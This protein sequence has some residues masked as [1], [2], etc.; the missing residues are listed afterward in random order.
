MRNPWPLAKV[1]NTEVP[2]AER[3]RGAREF[4]DMRACC[5]DAWCGQPLRGPICESWR[6][7][8]EADLH[9][10]MRAMFSRCVLTSTFI[11][12]CFA[13]LTTFTGA[14][15]SRHT[16]P[17]VASH[18]LLTV[19]DAA[20]KKW[21]ETLD[22]ATTS[23]NK[24]RPVTVKT[25]P[26]GRGTCGWH[27]YVAEKPLANYSSPQG[28]M[29]E[30]QAKMARW[31]RL[32]A[33]EQ[34]PYIAKAKK[35]RLAAKNQGSALDNAL[36][37]K[38]EE[39]G[40]PW[41]LSAC[42]KEVRADSSDGLGPGRSPSDWPIARVHIEQQMRELNLA[43]SCERWRREEGQVWGEDLD[44]PDTVS[45]AEPC[46]EGEC[47][48]VLTEAQRGKVAALGKHL[49]L[50]LRN[51]G[52]PPELLP[53]LE[54]TGCGHIIY[55]LVGDHGWMHEIRCELISLKR[56]G[57]ASGPGPG[58]SDGLGPGGSGDE[59]VAS[60]PFEL[61]MVQDVHCVHLD[62]AWPR[63]ESERAFLRR[64]VTLSSDPWEIYS[65]KALCEEVSTLMVEERTFM[66]LGAL[67]EAE[68]QRLVQLH[69]L[70]LL[71]KA[72][73]I[74]AG[75]TEQKRGR[76]KRGG[77]AQPR[78]ARRSIGSGDD[79]TSAESLGSPDGLRPGSP[80]N[81]ASSSKPDGLKPGSPD[82]LRPR[83]PENAA[84]SSNP[85]GLRPGSP[86]GREPGSPDGPRPGKTRKHKRGIP[87]GAGEWQLAEIANASG[88]IIGCGA[89]CKHHVDDAGD[90]ITCKKQVTL[91]KSGLTPRDLM[92]RLKRWL[93]A[94]L[95]DSP[96]GRGRAA[97]QACEHGREAPP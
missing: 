53:C 26:K 16:L 38:F 39:C 52:L 96:L 48:A 4:W 70:N 8:F 13:P 36:R 68:V 22:P 11:E 58:G 73:N 5:V 57:G 55:A 20:V 62:V 29:A 41:R 93:I 23:S 71:K 25:S 87:W 65:L 33:E 30:L 77:K 31:K 64:L 15:R 75:Q 35:E 56:P 37:D 21:W 6:G 19:F 2:M 14:F 51:I 60:L 74:R 97:Q 12:K 79:G 24:A 43:T 40:G 1:F 83:S 32:S 67:E 88:E 76:Q 63:V 27:L 34:A 84:S 91:W 10:F 49:R 47:L 80:E 72:D 78:R 89:I 42:L 94:G 92:L 9:E 69:A 90:T 7:L 17:S 86:D 44:F 82:G 54:F 28:N 46:F 66:D 95:D 50:V 18:H 45:M 61:A 85:D 59:D 3:E 81:A